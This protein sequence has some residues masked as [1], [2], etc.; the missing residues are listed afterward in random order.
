LFNNNFILPS[1]AHNVHLF[2]LHFSPH[3]NKY[4]FYC[5]CRSLLVLR[6]FH[7]EVARSLDCYLIIV[8]TLVCTFSIT[9][10][11]YSVNKK[12]TVSI[13]AFRSYIRSYY[14]KQNSCA[15]FTVRR[16]FN[17][18]EKSSSKVCVNLYF[19]VIAWRYDMSINGLSKCL[20]IQLN[21]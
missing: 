21:I 4:L 12:Y 18:R 16:K 15:Y 5:L 3:D 9:S 7:L 14:R 17:S 10:S 19:M 11:C 20:S 6:V 8:N 1:R 2:L 13:D